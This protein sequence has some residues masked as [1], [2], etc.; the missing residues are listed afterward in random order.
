MALQDLFPIAGSALQSLWGL[1]AALSLDLCAPPVL[2][3]LAKFP[4]PV[5]PLSTA[6]LGSVI[7]GRLFQ[8]CEGQQSKP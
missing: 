5:A 1:W 6:Q 8:D 3:L 4:G 7:L 2:Q